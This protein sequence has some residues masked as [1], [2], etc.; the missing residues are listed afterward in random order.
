MAGEEQERQRMAGPGERGL[1]VE[2][3]DVRHLQV[4]HDAAGRIGSSRW[5]RKSVADT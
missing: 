1:Q 4:G 2:P 3:A 5:A